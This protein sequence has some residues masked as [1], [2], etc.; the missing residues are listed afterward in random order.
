M[1]PDYQYAPRKPGEKKRR[2]SRKPAP[3]ANEQD[4]TLPFIDQEDDYYMAPESCSGIN[5][6]DMDFI[7]NKVDDQ[8]RRFHVDGD[9]NIGVVLP[10]CTNANL[11][12]MVEAREK[13]A[14]Q[15]GGPATFAPDRSSQIATTIPPY[16]Q[17][18]TDFFESLID[19][20]AIANDFKIVQGASG[21]HLAGIA[22]IEIGNPYLSLSDEDQRQLFESELERTLKFFD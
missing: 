14:T 22:G 3:A 7:G 19:W 21:E 20:D 2:A 9:G 4:D 10:A 18:D 8:V 11:S 5:D 17:N 16:V 15:E 1:H 12:E 13:L 6:D